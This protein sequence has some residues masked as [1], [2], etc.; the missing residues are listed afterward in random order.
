MPRLLSYLELGAGPPVVILPGYAMRPWT[1]RAVGTLLASR[2]R[3]IIP[4]LFD[5]EG[6]WR[7]QTVVEELKT[8]LD[9]LEADHVTLIGHSFGGAVELEFTVAYPRSVIELVFTDTLAMSREWM[10]AAEALRPMHLVWMATPVAIASFVDSWLKHPRQLVDAAWWGFRS[11]RR[12]HVGT[13][14]GMDLPCH[15]LWADRDS[16]LSR[17]D[18]RQFAA[19]LG[20]SFHVVRSAQGGRIDHDWMYRHPE[21]FV[22][23]L[24][25]LG[26]RALAVPL[27]N[28]PGR[29]PATA[30]DGHSRGL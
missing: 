25:K 26:L 2:C 6:P 4:D 16:L 5:C 18:G 1:Y 22:A 30:E 15:V 7:P 28:A 29:I 21:L 10:L 23:E 27:L 8:T 12:E 24:D 13:V 3:V 20:A 17:P 9:Y 19:D 11:D 14:A